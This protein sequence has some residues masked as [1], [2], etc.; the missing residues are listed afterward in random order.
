M[1]SAR[2]DFHF[3]SS[4]VDLGISNATTYHMPE[5][6]LSFSLRPIAIREKK[7]YTSPNLSDDACSDPNFFML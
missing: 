5:I 4:V 7:I 2:T 6:A 3:Q 1:E